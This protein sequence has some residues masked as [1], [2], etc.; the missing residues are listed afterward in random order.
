MKN[1]LK[2]LAVIAAITLTFALASCGNGTTNGSGTPVTGVTLDKTSVTLTVGGTETLTATVAPA[3]AT[4]KAV[5]WSSSNNA[6]ATVSNGAITAVAAGSA[7]ITV[8]TRDGG[9]TAQCTV[10]VFAGTFEDP[11]P[12]TEGVW[13][14]SSL[15]E[16]GEQWYK[17]TA[18][19]DTHYIHFYP[20]TLT[21][22]Y[23]QLHDAAGT[24]AGEKITLSE[25]TTNTSI[26]VT[27][28]SVYY[29]KVTAEGSNRSEY[30]I[31]FTASTTPPAVT[32]P[33]ANVITLA[34]GVWSD[35]SIPT[36]N[37]EQWY[38]F[39]A[40]A[41][42]NYIHFDPGTL[43]YVYVQLY[44]ADGAATGDRTRLHNSFPNT[45][46]K[47]T[48]GS[49]YYIKVTPYDSF[50]RG[51]YK[52]A[53]TTSTT[54]PAIP[55]PTENVT[56]IA[57]GVWADGSI[58][59]SGEQWF[60]F[61][62]SADTHYIHFVPGTMTQVYVQ[63]Y[64]AGGTTTGDRTYLAL[65]MTP[66]ISRTVTNGSVYYIK[67]IRWEGTGT[68]QITFNTS[69]T[70]P[71]ITITLP[72]ENI[73]TLTADAWAN[74]SIPTIGGEQWFTF[75]ATADTRYIHF[76]PGTLNSVYVQLYDANG[77][78]T[79]DR[80]QLPGNTT[81][82]TSITVTNG[83]VYYIKVTSTSYYITG[84]YQIGVTTTEIPPGT[85]VTT[86]TENVWADGSIPEHGEQWFTFTASATT[87][88]IHFDSGILDYV[89]VQLYE[90]DVTAT[91]D[92]TNLFT[93]F[94]NISRTVTNGSVY[95]IKVTPYGSY[96]GDYKLAFNTSTTRPPITITLPTE[97][98]TTLAEDEWEGGSIPTGDGEQWFKFTATAT[99][100]YIHFYPG[101][102]PWVYVQLYDAGGTTTGDRMLLRDDSTPHTSQT[103]TSGSV[104]YIKV[105]PFNNSYSGA[106]QIGFTTS[107]TPPAITLPTANVITLTADA[108]SNGS[109]PEG[110]EQWFKFTASATYYFIHFAP[111]TLTQVY[112]QLYDD[113]GI[114]TGNRESLG[115]DYGY[116]RN[117]TVTNGSV[118]YIKVTPYYS[119]YSGDYKLAF[120]TLYT[121]PSP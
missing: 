24:A 9:K 74:G 16:G 118:Y 105:T 114:A 87:Q 14:D 68:F 98:I 27:N 83:S 53:F 39:T 110:G 59:A 2:G 12:L 102:L 94:N 61:T 32:L 85:I 100:Q 28:G 64:E 80:L 81:N 55:L 108:W 29:I 120:S 119:S 19:A 73:T 117:K 34:E 45:S 82:N 23:V 97:N 70:A 96:S 42:T 21:W 22:V 91:G 18:S 44:D 65:D 71:A 78:A 33:T 36:Q 115:G 101:T 10:S 111:G 20:G 113:A 52:L 69:S 50:Y 49:V 77:V 6:V 62:A 93:N 90:A 95:Y 66:N 72:T 58:P 99:T 84:N 121:A 56:T 38:K 40:S 5:T 8:T 88:Y 54:A 86:L 103:V 43:E 48:N 106:Y 17:F 26:T 92:R 35:G 63:L 30:Q 107:T 13:A 104:Y 60:K 25:Y 47:V 89:Y 67:V 57:E 79:R 1:T 76:A 4:N 46:R 31:G 15:S 41:D 37:G 75:T 7:V 109:I 51:D 3:G 116:P 112:V 11:I